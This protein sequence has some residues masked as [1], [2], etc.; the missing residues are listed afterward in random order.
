M[1]IS[2]PVWHLTPASLGKRG[3]GSGRVI[4]SENLPGINFRIYLNMRCFRGI[5]PKSLAE[6][7]FIEAEDFRDQTLITYPLNEA[8]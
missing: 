1:W 8:D 4:R 3:C 6:K 7:A 5:G 2:G